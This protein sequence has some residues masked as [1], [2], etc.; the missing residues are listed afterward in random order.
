MV[1]CVVT[2]IGASSRTISASGHW[3]NRRTLI[4]RSIKMTE[5]SDFRKRLLTLG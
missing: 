5:L 2:K 4:T 3:Q 1:D